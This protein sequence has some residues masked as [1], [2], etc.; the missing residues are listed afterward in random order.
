MRQEETPTPGTYTIK[1]ES[2]TIDADTKFYV[3]TGDLSDEVSEDTDLVEI[4]VTSAIRPSRDT[5]TSPDHALVDG[6]LTKVNQRK[7]K[8][9]DVITYTLQLRAIVIDA[10]GESMVVDSAPDKSK[11][12]YILTDSRTQGV[13][14]NIHLVSTVLEPDAEGR[15]SFPITHPNPTD[16]DD[17][18]DVTVS[19]TLTRAQDNTAGIAGS[20]DTGAFRDADGHGVR[21]AAE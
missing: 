17:D 15:A 14:N 6:G 9:D 19:L 20:E 1:D 13:D 18:A 21:L 11:N 8:F 2:P 12:Q 4:T 3:F 10:E 7:V 16:A 5:P